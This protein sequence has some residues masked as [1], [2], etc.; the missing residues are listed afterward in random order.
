[1][2][3]RIQSFQHQQF[4]SVETWQNR[5]RTGFLIMPKRPCEWRVDSHGCNKFDNAAL[6]FGHRD[7]TAHLL[8]FLHIR[9][10]NLPGPDSIMRS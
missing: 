4:V 3:F 8:V 9:T 10:T 7:Q 6:G 2:C 5:E 1:M